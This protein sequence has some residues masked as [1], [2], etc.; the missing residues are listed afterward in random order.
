LKY[1]SINVTKFTRLYKFSIPGSPS[2]VNKMSPIFPAYKV[3][4]CTQK[5]K[6]EP[7]QKYSNSKMKR[8]F[9]SGLYS[10]T[11][12]MRGI[13]I[14]QPRQCP[15]DFGVRGFKSEFLNFQRAS[16]SKIDSI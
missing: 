13:A 5:V 6:S 2:I 12:D 11:K 1:F 16:V 7:L 14:A 9:T 15:T 4:C 8:Q 3:T 10:T